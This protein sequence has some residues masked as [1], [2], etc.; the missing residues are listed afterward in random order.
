MDFSYL[1]NL[2]TFDDKPDNHKNISL[3]KSS[4]YF[5]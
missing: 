2:P 5:W 3:S 4:N 1:D